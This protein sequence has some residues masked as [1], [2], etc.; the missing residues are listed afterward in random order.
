MVWTTKRRIS[1]VSQK[2]NGNCQRRGVVEV[3]VWDVFLLLGSSCVKGQSAC[4]HLAKRDAG[5]KQRRKCALPEN[6]R[7]DCDIPSTLERWTIDRL[8]LLPTLLLVSAYSACTATK[9]LRTVDGTV[10]RRGAD[11]G[12]RRLGSPTKSPGRVNLEFVFSIWT[13]PASY[14]IASPPHGLPL[15]LRARPRPPRLSQHALNVSHLL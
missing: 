15:R 4:V 2:K 11:S 10:R 12:A 6:C 14:R 9:A 8:I 13:H 3:D 7:R 1:V 5:S